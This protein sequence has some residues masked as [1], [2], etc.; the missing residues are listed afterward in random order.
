MLGDLGMHP[1]HLLPRFAYMKN[2]IPVAGRRAPGGHLPI[3]HRPGVLGARRRL[4]RPRAGQPLRGR[5][6]RLPEHRRGEPGADRD[7]ERD[8]G[9]RPPARAPG[10]DE[11]RRRHDRPLRGTDPT[12]PTATRGGGRRGRRRPAHLSRRRPRRA[13]RLRRQAMATS[14]RGQVLIPW[15]N[16]VEDGSYRFDGREHQLPINEVAT[17]NAIHGLVR[18]VV[19]D[20]SS[21]PSDRVVLEHVLHPQP[22][23]PF[24]LPSG[25]STRSAGRAGVCDDGRERGRRAVS[26]RGGPAPVPDGRKHNRRRG[27]PACP[28]HAASSAP[29]T[30]ACR[31]M[32]GPWP[33]RGS[34]SASRVGSGTRARHT[35]S[36]VSSATADGTAR[37]RLE[38]RRPGARALGGRGLPVPA[39]VHR[40]PAR[41]RQAPQPR[42]GTDDLPAER[43]AHR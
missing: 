12:S 3:R 18:W 16:R 43:P 10:A 36:R 8:P 7:G 37:A 31:P 4:P 32:R 1:D 24:A 29:M 35:A 15:P 5:H 22:G 6:Q 38:A 25:S 41:R 28:G 13:R 14:G 26:V 2:E 9:R 11:P 19:V 34:T 30:A 33:G 42:G 21:A 39:G 20:W 23:Y 27:E 17:G 40:R